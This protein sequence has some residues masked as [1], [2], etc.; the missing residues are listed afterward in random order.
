MGS[1]LTN[2]IAQD[3]EEHSNLS[4]ILSFCKHVG[5]EYA[6]LTSRRIILLAKKYDVQLPSSTLLTPEKQQNVKTLLRDYHQTVCKHL[7]QEH[8]E[9][10]NAERSKRKAMESRGEISNN[11]REELEMMS[12]NYEKLFQSTITLSDLLNENMPEIPKEVDIQNDPSLQ[13]IDESGDVVLDPW[14]DE[15]TKS[16]YVDLPDLRQFLPNY[17]GRKETS[18]PLPE[19]QQVTE[20]ALDDETTAEPELNVEE[21]AIMM[22]IEQEAAKPDV[23]KSAIEMPSIVED[24]SP[25]AA[26]EPENQEVKIEEKL[27]LEEREKPVPTIPEKT[28]ILGKQQFDTFLANLPNCV[29]RELIDSAAIDFLLNFNN[30]PNRKR[31]AKALFNVHRTRLDLLPLLA[32]CCAIINLVS[33]DVALELSQMLKVDFKFHVKKRDQINIESKIKVVRYIGEMVKFTLYTRLEALMCLKFLLSNFQH[34]HIEMTCAFLEVCGMYLYN[35]KDSR[36]RTNVYLEQMMRLKKAMTLDTRHA[37][38][39]ENCYYLVKPPENGAK[40]RRKLRTPMQNYIRFLIF[41]ELH[42][43][44]VEKIVKYLRRLNWD[45]LKV[46]S[47]VVRCLTKA[48]IF[49]W[50]LIRSLADV[51]SALSS[52]QEKAV[53]RVIDCV[54]EDVRAGLEIHSPMLAQRRI[55]MAKFL[56]ELYIYRLIDSQNVF[57]TLYSIISYGVTWNHEIPSPVDPPESMFRLK[58]ACTMLDTCGSYFQSSSSKKK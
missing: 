48:Y 8:K 15:D 40:I 4:I 5:E 44:N 9:L 20:E 10:Q 50:H 22:E 58:L 29:N 46:S 13:I 57:N 53:T 33:P 26:T 19:V 2:L 1:I 12:S 27:L 38:Q 35:C 25:K 55:A 52:F 45:D 23:E 41:Q 14:G 18:E 36:F 16:F 3:K 17:H 51:V 56:A 49:R 21:Q 39:I 43:G 24:E 7:K 31:L 47:Y 42:K 30:K 6:G 32:R 34:H 28:Q 11:K 37:T 54:F